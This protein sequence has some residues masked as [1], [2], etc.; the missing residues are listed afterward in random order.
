MPAA[1]RPYGLSIPA[2]LLLH[3][4]PT[5]ASGG[6]G[7]LLSRTMLSNHELP[8]VGRFACGWHRLA[9]T[10]PG[11]THVGSLRPLPSWP[12]WTEHEKV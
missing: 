2:S 10:D 8:Y 5:S 12:P 1:D 4:T 9:T 6:Q 7:L 11:A 3:L